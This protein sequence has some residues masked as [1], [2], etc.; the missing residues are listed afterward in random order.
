MDK[1]RDSVSRL[2]KKIKHR[3][4]GSKD[5]SRGTGSKADRE[6]IDSAGPPPQAEPHVVAGSR[7][8]SEGNEANADGRRVSS[9]DRPLQ[10]DI[11]EA[12]SV[13]AR[14]SENDQEKGEAD[15][16][17]REV[18]QHPGVKVAVGSGCVR[19]GNDD[20]GQKVE[21]GYISPS[22]ASI[23]CREKPESTRTRLFWFLLL[24]I[25]ADN[26]DTSATPEMAVLRP[27]ESAEPSASADEKKT[28]WKSNASAAAKLLLR[29]VRDSVDAFGPLKSVAGGLCFILENHEVRFSSVSAIYVA[30]KCPSELKQISKR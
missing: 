20:G 1:M 13:P 26:A 8:D 25:L 16:S 6:S 19:D 2:K 22:T 23:P 15:I 5:K 3:L 18:S 11:D 28:S 29:G 9:M 30:H 10:P 21:R 12:E 27:Y 14:G 4:A 24:I 7:H 17:R